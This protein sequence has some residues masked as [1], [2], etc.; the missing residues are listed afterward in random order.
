[1]VEVWKATLT[2]REGEVFSLVDR[3]TMD[4]WRKSS[5][6]WARRERSVEGAWRMFSLISGLRLTP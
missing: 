6:A 2:T 3:P 1:M 5:V 4:F